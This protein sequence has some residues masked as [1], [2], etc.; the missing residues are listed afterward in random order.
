M[1]PLW[2]AFSEDS[3][4][5]NIK[6]GKVGRVGGDRPSNNLPGSPLLF[7][8]HLTTTNHVWQPQQASRTFEGVSWA[9]LRAL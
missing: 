8:S 3:T 5:L 7:D 9:Q 1:E 2:N 6:V 4:D